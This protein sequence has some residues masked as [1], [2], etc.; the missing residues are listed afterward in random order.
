MEEFVLN[1]DLNE[2]VDSLLF[3]YSEDAIASY[4]NDKHIIKLVITGSIQVWD[5]KFEKTYRT[6]KEYPDALVQDIKSNRVY[7][8]DRWY[9]DE[10]NEFSYA[11]YEKL[12]NGDIEFLDYEMVGSS[13]FMDS[14]NGNLSKITPEQLEAEMKY[15]I[16]KY[17]ESNED[18]EF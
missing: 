16:E 18:N 4:T 3:D 14:Y 6:A 10:Y 8:E 9:I 15:I 13:V 12:D 7:D 17:Y 11:V 1:K 5:N 2:Y